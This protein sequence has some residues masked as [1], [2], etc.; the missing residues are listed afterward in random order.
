MHDWKPLPP[1]IT[2]WCTIVSLPALGITAAGGTP[3]SVPDVPHA[4]VLVSIAVV[5]AVG[6][7]FLTAGYK[8]CDSA[9]GGTMSLLNSVFS[10][11]FGVALLG[12]ELQWTTWAG[13]GLTL[14]ACLFLIAPHHGAA[15]GRAPAARPRNAD[16]ADRTG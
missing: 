5:A 14:G 8:D 10:V 11:A 1:E 9:E 6:Q 4:L 16:G 15:H 2:F 3:L 13:G 12:E 7:V